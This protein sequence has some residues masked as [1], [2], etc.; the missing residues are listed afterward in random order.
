MS[1]I[2]ASTLRTLLWLE[3]QSSQQT[4]ASN[5]STHHETTNDGGGVGKDLEYT[6]LIGIMKRYC[7]SRQVLTMDP[8]LLPQPQ[9]QP[10]PYTQSLS[11]PQSQQLSS[12]TIIKSNAGLV[13][14]SSVILDGGEVCDSD[15]ED[16][17]PESDHGDDDHDGDQE[18]G[19]GENE[20]EGEEDEEEEDVF[21]DAIEGI[22]NSTRSLRSMMSS[23]RSGQHQQQ[24]LFNT[25]ATTSTTTSTTTIT[26]RKMVRRVTMGD[27]GEGGGMEGSVYG[28]VDSTAI[29]SSSGSGGGGGGG[30]GGG[31]ALKS[32]GSKGF[33]SSVGEGGEEGEQSLSAD[34]SM[35]SEMFRS[36]MQGYRSAQRP[37]LPGGI[38]LTGIGGG[39]G[40]GEGVANSVQRNSTKAKGPDN[41]RGSGRGGTDKGSVRG[42]TRGVGDSV[43]GS[44]YGVTSSVGGTTGKKPIIST[45]IVNLPSQPTLSAYPLTSSPQ[46]T[47]STPPLPH[48][49]TFPHVSLSSPSPSFTF[50]TFV[51]HPLPE[52]CIIAHETRLRVH[53][54]TAD[55]RFLD[56]KHDVM[57]AWEEG[58]GE[59]NDGD[60]EYRRNDRSATTAATAATT[61]SPTI[62]ENIT[63]MPVLPVSPSQQPPPT[64]PTT[65]PPLR[66]YNEICM[67]V[68]DMVVSCTHTLTHTAAPGPGLGEA[69]TR[70]TVSVVHV[71]VEETKVTF[72]ETDD[73]NHSSNNNHSNSNNNNNNQ[74]KS[75]ETKDEDGNDDTHGAGAD[76]LHHPLLRKGFNDASRR[77][78]RSEPLLSFR[79]ATEGEGEGG[80][81]GLSE[82]GSDVDA[83]KPSLGVST[84]QE[85]LFGGGRPGSGGSGGSG[86]GGGSHTL[87][88]A[89]HVDITITVAP[90]ANHP[91]LPPPLGVDKEIKGDGGGRSHVSTPTSP[92]PHDINA[93]ILP[94]IPPSI[95][96]FSTNNEG[97]GMTSGA[98]SAVNI[99]VAVQLQPLVCS[100]RLP[101][102]NR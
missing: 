6:H 5:N 74:S 11:Q 75:S 66:V 91:H 57:E 26:R 10:Q 79:T 98:T 22:G 86:G 30:G 80:E 76:L 81:G 100:L 61:T 56:T 70:A 87:I 64:S 72:G 85:K 77:I 19:V 17:F 59:D 42:V 50:S 31:R 88:E 62:S 2:P 36:A 82:G 25:N 18:N 99:T 45:Y 23:S 8:T 63:C 13:G 93:P 35:G 83:D 92:S 27:S 16:D 53:I 60:E 14:G 78:L 84:P 90:T 7:V 3:S 68:E 67:H 43:S 29:A 65:S 38:G 54:A 58:S 55:M 49:P 73:N 97:E 12:S 21:E 9:P 47:L 39:G 101:R 37:G 1:K 95:S 28:S 51:S 24:C 46:D 48:L 96:S 40:G 33:G 20:N 44:T 69:T 52:V 32:S 71:G 102:A 34:D 4:H 94:S 89:P 15:G 41:V